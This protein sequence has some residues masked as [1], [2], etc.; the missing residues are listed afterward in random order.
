MKLLAWCS[1]GLVIWVVMVVMAVAAVAGSQTGVNTACGAP[2]QNAPNPS[3]HYSQEQIE[4]LWVAVGGPPDQ[5][6]I[7]GAVGMAE[8]GG[9]PTIVNSIGA[10]GLMQIHPP[11]PDYLDP[12]TNMRIAVRKYR[13]SGWQPWE[14]YTNG[15]YLRWM[16]NGP[17]PELPSPCLPIPGDS[18]RVLWLGGEWPVALPDFPG[19]SCDPR[20]IPD[21]LQLV[22]RYRILVSDCYSLDPVHASSGEHPL[23]LAVDLVPAPGGSWDLVDELAAWAEP[24]QDH[25]RDPFRWV[26]YNGDSNHGRGNHL[27]L[28]WQ[29]GPGR[30]AE[31]V[32]VLSVE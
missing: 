13:E 16:H 27:H 23:G 21:L 4:K 3:G 29:H 15:R 7:A 25:P 6:K 12:E 2:D 24:Q 31:W 22:Q 26:G 32:S 5:A 17:T 11:E 19:E 30:P 20:I 9:D 14:A 28:S 18:H 8:S 1:A 10:G